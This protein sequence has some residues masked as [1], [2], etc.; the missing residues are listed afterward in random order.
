MMGIG[1]VA[2]SQSSSHQYVTVV[3]EPD[4]ADW[5]YRTGETAHFTAYAIKEN[6]RMRDTEITYSYGPDKLDAVFTKTVKTDRNGVAHFDVPGAKV[7]GFTS[8]RVK[9]KHDGHTYSSMT[10][11]GFDPYSIEPTTTMP[12]DFEQFWSDAV[13]KASQLPM[14]PTLRHS[15]KESNDRVDVYYLRLQSYKRGNYVFNLNT[16]LY[17]DVD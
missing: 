3:A 6:V 14:M 13:K 17:I 1:L 7:P 11:I 15:E 12:P 5:I 8:V 2:L 16:G 4:H 10:N 9:V